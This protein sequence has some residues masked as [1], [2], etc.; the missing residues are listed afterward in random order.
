MSHF[1]G[2]TRLEAFSDAVIA[3]IMT[4][5][6]L[7]L[8]VPHSG[9]L[10]SLLDMSTIFGIYVLSF[11][12]IGVYW[13]S[14][15]HILHAAGKIT[16]KTLIA[17]MFLLFWLSLMPFATNWMGEFITKPVPVAFYGIILFMSGFSITVLQY[18][19]VKDD[20]KSLLAQSIGNNKKSIFSVI[21]YLIAIP[22]SF[23]STIISIII[24]CGV[25]LSWFIPDS[26]IEKNFN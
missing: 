26:R 11:V 14:H 16:G 24:Y 13:N 5:M 10:H 25:G 18:I 20:P 2:K 21:M 22:I 7:E 3:I 1:I 8:K 12:Y 17:N 23:Y 6:V 19:L 9:D 15:H 4:I